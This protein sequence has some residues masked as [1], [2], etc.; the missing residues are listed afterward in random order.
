[1]IFLSRREL[2]EQASRYPHYIL[3]ASDFSGH[4]LDWLMQIK[5]N[6]DKFNKRF[7]VICEDASRL[8]GLRISVLNKVLVY[9]S[10][11][12][13]SFINE[14]VGRKTQHQIMFWDADDQLRLLL[15]AQFKARCVIMRPYLT[16]YK[17]M[18]I[19]RYWTKMM[20]ILYFVLF[21]RHNVALLGI[22]EAKPHFLKKHWVDEPMGITDDELILVHKPSS[23]KFRSDISRNMRVLIPGYIT[24]R[25]NPLI[26]I[27]ACIELRKKHGL[28]IELTFCGTIDANLR[29]NI[30]KLNLEWV[31]LVDGYLERKQFLKAIGASDFILLPYRNRGSSGIVLESLALAK[32]VVLFGN[33]HWQNLSRNTKGQLFLLA[34]GKSGIVRGFLK[35][36]SSQLVSSSYRIS[37]DDRK[38]ALTFLT[39][40]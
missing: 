38:T 18:S 8:K 14:F 31:H 28:S 29:K 9:E 27:S 32:V 13:L 11:S 3:V 19:L 34:H 36:Q 30:E 10:R 2:Y 6:L 25:K 23:Q 21:D 1:M 26:A 7:I 40:S 12:G 33:R 15:F 35:L 39:S 24:L 4:R 17:L 37:N 16:E 5:S 20:I 22:A